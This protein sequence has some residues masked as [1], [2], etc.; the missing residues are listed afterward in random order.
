MKSKLKWFYL[1]FLVY[2]IICGQ[3]ISPPSVFAEGEQVYCPNSDQ[4][5]ATKLEIINLDT[6]AL[7]S[8]YIQISI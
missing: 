7:N 5:I 1:F 6:T 4:L 3:E 2:N 8:V